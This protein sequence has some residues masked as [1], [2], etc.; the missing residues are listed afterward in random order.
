MSILSGIFGK[1]SRR[2]NAG[3]ATCDLIVQF[4]EVSPQ[5]KVSALTFTELFAFVFCEIDSVLY[6]R[7]I[8]ARAAV[9]DSLTAAYT[10]TL[11]TH[12]KLKPMEA[13]EHGQML[14]RRIQEYGKMFRERKEKSD[15]VEKLHFYLIQASRLDKYLIDDDSPIALVDVFADRESAEGLAVFYIHKLVPLI[16]VIVAKNK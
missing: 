14:A 10:D 9:A 5:H 16:E 11:R 13:M 8:P 3:D 4:L 2:P 15:I 12:L 7:N 6:G 1:R